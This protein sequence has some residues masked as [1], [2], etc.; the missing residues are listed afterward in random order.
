MLALQEIKVCL[1]CNPDV[2][3]LG[4]SSR[5]MRRHPME[6]CTHWCLRHTVYNSSNV[7][8]SQTCNRCSDNQDAVYPYS[9]LS[10]SLRRDRGHAEMCRNLAGPRDHNPRRT[11]TDSTH[12][13]PDRIKLQTGIRVVG[14]GGTGRGREAAKLGHRSLKCA[15]N[16]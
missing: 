14:A 4:T 6:V 10:P 16:N 13:G 12:E 7:E 8:S 5:T 1:P 2:S 15:R 11:N 3:S 9:E